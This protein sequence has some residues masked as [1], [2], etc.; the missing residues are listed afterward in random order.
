MA[1]PGQP[2]PSQGGGAP[3]GAPDPSQGGGSPSQAPASPE[4]MMLGKISEALKQLS[5]SK[6]ETSSG[7]Q[8]AIQGINEAQ[9]ALVTSPQQSPSQSPPY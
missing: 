1:S 6:P 7:L 4:M 8:K 3:S 9:S 5:Q 2:D